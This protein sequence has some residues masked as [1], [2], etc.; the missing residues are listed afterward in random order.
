[1]CGNYD[2]DFK[3]EIIF[4]FVVLDW[5]LTAIVEL[6]KESFIASDLILSISL[7]KSVYFIYEKQ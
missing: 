1:M 5:N 4:N 3:G 7:L 6:Y 2:Q